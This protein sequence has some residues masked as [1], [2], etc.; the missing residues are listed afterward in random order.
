MRFS[1]SEGAV[2]LGS[3]ALAILVLGAQLLLSPT[4]DPLAEPL[5][6]M[7]S[8]AGLSSQ[9]VDVNRASVA[10]LTKL[11]GIGPRLAERIVRYRLQHGP[12]RS[13]EELLRVRGIGSATLR[14]LLPWIQICA[15]RPPCE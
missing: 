2:L 5:S 9:R 15:S 14:D 8:E 6:Q 3:A 13:P 4:L 12:F 1:R 11:P 10:E 7:G